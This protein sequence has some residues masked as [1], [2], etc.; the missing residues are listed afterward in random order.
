MKLH[1]KNWSWFYLG[2]FA[3]VGWV[4]LTPGFVGFRC[5]QANLH[6]AAVI[7]K[8]ETQQWPISEPSS[9]SIFFD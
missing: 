6:I 5:T 2:H 7:A 1:I 8:C 3:F 9:K 4:E